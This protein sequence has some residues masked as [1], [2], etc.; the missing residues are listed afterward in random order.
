MSDQPE[1]RS[2][3]LG[4]L[5]FYAIMALGLTV[6]CVYVSWNLGYDAGYKECES[7]VSQ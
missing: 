4:L 2:K 6:L 1:E 3:A 7:E 5:I